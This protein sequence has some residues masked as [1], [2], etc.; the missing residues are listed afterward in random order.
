VARFMAYSGKNF[1]P[2]WMVEGSNTGW[3]IIAER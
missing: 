1:G 2:R 3:A